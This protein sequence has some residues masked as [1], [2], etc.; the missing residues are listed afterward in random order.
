MEVLSPSFAWL[1]LQIDEAKV[2]CEEGVDNSVHPNHDDFLLH[3][4]TPPFPLAPQTF[5]P[6]ALGYVCAGFSEIVL[7]TTA[8]LLVNPEP[9]SQRNF[10]RVTVLS[11]VAFVSGSGSCPSQGPD[12]ALPV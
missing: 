8:L 9:K 5:H 12:F 4:T 1:Y 7:Y 10:G 2:S 3:G 11:A 6:A